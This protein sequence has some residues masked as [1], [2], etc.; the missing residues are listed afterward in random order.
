MSTFRNF[1]WVFR[2]LIVEVLTLP[3]SSVVIILSHTVWVELQHAGV[4]ARHSVFIGLCWHLG[5]Y[6]KTQQHIYIQVVDTTDTRRLWCLQLPV[7]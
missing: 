7:M 3:W 2:G 6:F 4:W 5:V 1:E